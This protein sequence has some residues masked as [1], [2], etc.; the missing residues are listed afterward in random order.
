MW[1]ACSSIANMQN[2]RDMR[3]KALTKAVPWALPREDSY[4]SQLPTP[5]SANATHSEL[6]TGQCH[7]LGA[8]HKIARRQVSDQARMKIASAKG[9]ARLRDRAQRGWAPT[10]GVRLPSAAQ[11]K[12][13]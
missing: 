7:A 11:K 9:G 4:Y 1:R 10:E 8:A 5:L 2:N 12:T 3:W 6:A 13:L